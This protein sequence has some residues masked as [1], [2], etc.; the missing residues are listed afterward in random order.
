MSRTARI[1]RTSTLAALSS[2][3]RVRGGAQQRPAHVAGRPVGDRRR[4]RDAGHDTCDRTADARLLR[5]RRL[6]S[7]AP[8]PLCPGSRLDRRAS[9]G[10]SSRCS[11]SR[12][13]SAWTS[14]P[15][16]RSL[17]GLGGSSRRDRFVG[18]GREPARGSLLGRMRLAGVVSGTGMA[19]LGI[20][21]LLGGED[22]L[23]TY[24]GGILYQFGIPIW[25]LLMASELARSARN[26][27]GSSAEA[28][29]R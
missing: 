29:N 20:G 12:G 25:A 6:D 21:L 5:A 8:R 11:T 14:R 28:A 16:A 17:R 4:R 2:P 18:R 24:V 26:Q 27:A 3:G 7:H 15:R 13:R 1:V 22:Q 19:A 23:L 9:P 10:R